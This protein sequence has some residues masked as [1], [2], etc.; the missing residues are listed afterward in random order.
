VLGYTIEWGQQRSSIPKSFHPDYPDMV[1][2][3]EEVTAGLLAFCL[4]VTRR[5]LNRPHAQQENF[6]FA[7]GVVRQLIY[8]RTER[9]VLNAS[10]E[11]LTVNCTARVT[12]AAFVSEVDRLMNP[13]DDTRVILSLSGNSGIKFTTMSDVRHL[14][15]DQAFGTDY[16]F[17]R[18]DVST[19]QSAFWEALPDE[20]LT[21]VGFGDQTS[22]FTEDSL[23]LARRLLAAT[24][25]SAIDLDEVLSSFR[26]L[27]QQ[28]VDGERPHEMGVP[29]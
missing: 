11:V 17:V 26:E 25:T 12:P 28:Y 13:N 22:T 7:G 23:G 16:E 8:G 6:F 18:L 27:A 14:L 9:A 10:A 3:I 1:P 21:L 15:V 2:I 20:S 5:D 4:E 19:T 29:K 24:V